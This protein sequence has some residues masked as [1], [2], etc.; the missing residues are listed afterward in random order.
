MK[1][2]IISLFIIIFFFSLTKEVMIID[3]I[4]PPPITIKD[5]IDALNAQKED[6]KK[7]FHQN[8]GYNPQYCNLTKVD[9]GHRSCYVSFYC[10]ECEQWYYFCGDI[11]MKEYDG[12]QNKDENKNFVE[13]Y[14]IVDTEITEEFNEEK[15]NKLKIDC[16][17][18][19]LKYISLIY[20][21]YS[22]LLL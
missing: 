14:I 12:Y 13:N 19:K 7:T 3:K 10:K 20:I 8:D 21:I 15:G 2:L 22:I 4:N 18:Q 11:N 9:D 1:H 5:F 16:V 17:S 6:K